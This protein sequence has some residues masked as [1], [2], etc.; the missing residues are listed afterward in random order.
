MTHSVSAWETDELRPSE[1]ISPSM[2]SV[3]QPVDWETS[4]LKVTL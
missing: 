4:L 3:L 1:K 2:K